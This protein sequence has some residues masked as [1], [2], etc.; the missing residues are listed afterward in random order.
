M[1]KVTLHY[2]SPGFVEIDPDELWKSVVGV[3][4]KS[5]QSKF[6]ELTVTLL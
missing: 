6:S 1:F 2:P 4:N 3:V 5:L